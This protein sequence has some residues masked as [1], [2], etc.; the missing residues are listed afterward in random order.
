[1]ESGGIQHFKT[2][3]NNFSFHIS[4]HSKWWTAFYP[5]LFNNELF[6][7]VIISVYHSFLSSLTSIYSP[8]PNSII[9]S[10]ISMRFSHCCWC[11]NSKI[12]NTNVFIRQR[13]NFI[14]LYS[15][16]SNYFK[17]RFLII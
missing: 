11:A 10:I 17:S 3:S 5:F 4:N 14:L 13:I 2:R 15:T 1:M 16:Y 6:F 9:N 8:L 7:C 12:G